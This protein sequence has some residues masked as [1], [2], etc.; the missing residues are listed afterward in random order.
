MAIEIPAVRQFNRVFTGGPRQCQLQCWQDPRARW[1]GATQFSPASEIRKATPLNFCRCPT[2]RQRATLSERP[3]L[4]S[5]GLVL[6][7]TDLT[8]K[9]DHFGLLL[10]RGALWFTPIIAFLEN[11]VDDGLRVQ[12]EGLATSSTVRFWSITTADKSGRNPSR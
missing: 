11:P 3:W 2:T 5:A 9:E 4:Y 8:T 10:A 6:L 12:S 7:A 1:E